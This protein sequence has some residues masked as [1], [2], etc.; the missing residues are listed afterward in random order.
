MAD[1]QVGK[2]H[3]AVE[4]EPEFNGDSKEQMKKIADILARGLAKLGKNM[5]LDVLEKVFEE[6]FK[7]MNEVMNQQLVVMKENMRAF[8]EAIKDMLA[9]SKFNFGPIAYDEPRSDAEPTQ[10]SSTTNT[11]RGPPKVKIKMPK[12]DLSQMSKQDEMDLLSQ[13][14]LNTEELLNAQRLQLKQYNE[15]LENLNDINDEKSGM[16]QELSDNIAKLKQL[17]IGI[18]DVKQRMSGMSTMREKTQGKSLIY[19]LE[20]EITKVTQ[21]IDYL[22]S[23]LSELG[24]IDS[25][26]GVE[27]LT[28]KIGK[29][30]STIADSETYLSSMKRKLNELSEINQPD[31]FAGSEQLLLSLKNTLPLFDQLK[32]SVNEAAS[33]TKYLN[34]ITMQ[35]ARSH[36]LFGI[37]ANGI[38]SSRLGMFISS[39]GAKMSSLKTIAGGLTIRLASL[40]F[41]GLNKVALGAM[42]LS[43]SLITSGLNRFNAGLRSAGKSAVSFAG[44][45]LGISRASRKASAGM[46]GSRMSLGRLVK[47]FVVFSLVFPLVSR[48]IMAL[49]RSIGTTLMANESFA[50]S[51]DQIKS[52]LMASFMPIYNAIL[53]ALNSFM[54][55]LANVTAHFAAFISAI[56][57][58][59]YSASINAAKGMVEAKDAMGAYGSAAKKAAKDANQSVMAFDKLNK[60]NG[61][62]DD[63]GGG[64]APNIIPTDI[65]TSSASSLA[66]K[67]KKMFEE[68]DYEGIGQLIGEGINR[69][70]A[71]ITQFIDWSNVGGKI[72]GIVY[73]ITRI[74]NSAVATIDWNAAGG[75][76]G[77]GINTVANTIKMFFEGIN[78]EGL[79]QSLGNGLS[80]LVH[81]VD[82]T[83]LGQTFGSYFQA[84]ING[85]YGF[86]T[87]ADWPGLGKGLADG[88]MGLY[89]Y[90][91]AGRI[92]QLIGG[93]LQA[94]IS[95]AH[96]FVT[97]IDWRS[98]GSKTASSINNFFSSINWA[99]FGL[100]FSQAV[101]GLFGMLRQALA[102]IDWLQIGIDLA[103]FLSNVDWLGLLLDVGVI[104]G[105][106]FIGLGSVILR[107]VHELGANIVQGFYQ[108][109]IDLF[110][111]PF[112]WVR[113]HIV[114]PFLN[115]IKD[116]FGIHS[117]STVLAEIGVNLIHGLING[118]GS[119]IGTLISNVAVWF[120]GIA[121]TISGTW[122]SIKENASSAW[123]GICSGV[124]GFVG[125]IKTSVSD[126]FAGAKQFAIEHANSLKTGVV[127]AF[128]NMK[129]GIG[130]LPGQLKSIASDM[131]NRMSEGVN[132]TIGNVKSAIT[133]GIDSA[134]NYITSLPQKAISWGAD[135]MSGMANGIKGAA[136]WV[137]DA[138][139]GV[140]GKISSWLHFSRPD[141]GPLREYETWMPDMMQGLSKTMTASAPLLLGNIKSLASRI[142]TTMQDI[143]PQVAF[144]GHTT[145]NDQYNRS[146]ADPS[147]EILYVLKEIVGLLKSTNTGSSGGTTSQEIVLKIGDTEFARIVIAAI[148][149]Y[150]KETGRQVLIS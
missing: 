118:I 23:K 43:R 4:L 124:G 97:N 7:N 25:A 6:C 14:I 26:S 28:V 136:G 113:E 58:T 128:E 91:D 141:V 36:Q 21:D 63:A 66:E 114:D 98:L 33:R 81:K 60:L 93:T 88:A 130:Q 102:D 110:T 38:K 68:Q 89:N 95:T 18:A 29:L 69:G 109:I 107:G 2:I 103:T 39:L 64:S 145:I 55:A 12:V 48:G 90:I 120:G 87:T 106:A 65:D 27:G 3:L 34:G 19:I 73:G 139:S 45:L 75:M 105:R 133:T 40:A 125:N 126:G 59:T 150:E 44:K 5:K 143:Q 138:V 112:A 13:K 116:L 22:R 104:I 85:L 71:K 123:E 20:N 47:S 52:N 83:N 119:I 117:P 135:M 134:I 42:N 61:K 10:T 131:F 31:M 84:R 74:F 148:K 127:S 53:P 54:S 137:S 41:S 35:A 15:E 115:A 99:E 49:G 1:E 79:G 72:T 62:N 108:G 142:S 70:V 122:T 111:D 101:R 146:D 8:I 96:N 94:A 50:R 80:G 16:S 121:E 17:K 140:A 100:T 9:D 77:T 92:G 57:G 67:I 11:A 86:I 82:W 37:V 76:F 51:L 132:S 32:H 56:F 149:K 144:T 30:K 46:N 78:W 129:N 147:T 24:K